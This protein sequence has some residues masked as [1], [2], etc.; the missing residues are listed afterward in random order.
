[1]KLVIKKGLRI[2]FITP[3]KKNR[4]LCT[5]LLTKLG[6]LKFEIFNSFVFKAR[7]PPSGN[8]FLA[9][10]S[11]LEYENFFIFSNYRPTSKEYR[12]PS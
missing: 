1:M 4:S 5:D 11:E 3:K 12:I 10:A 2:S 9:Y 7:C 8:F 6:L